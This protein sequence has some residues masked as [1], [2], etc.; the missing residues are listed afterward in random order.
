MEKQGLILIPSFSTTSELQ[1]NEPGK[2]QPIFPLHCKKQ[3]GS[4]MGGREQET[5]GGGGTIP[6]SYRHLL[7]YPSFPSIFMLRVHI[8]L[9]II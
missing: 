7:A 8:L 9:V 6:G 4:A 5:V 3:M 1:G 2:V